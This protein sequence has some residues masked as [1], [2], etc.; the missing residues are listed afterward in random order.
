MKKVFETIGQDQKPEGSSADP[1]VEARVRLLRARVL[2][3]QPACSPRVNVAL[4]A[5]SACRWLK[6]KISGLASWIVKRR[7]KPQVTGKSD[8]ATYI[9]KSVIHFCAALLLFSFLC[10]ALHAQQ[11]AP[12]A[13]VAG[14][15]RLM[16]FS[17]KLTDGE[18]RLLPSVT[19]VTFSIYKDQEGGAPVWLETQNARPD[20]AGRYTVQLGA[21]KSEGLP[22]DLFSSGE[23]RWLGVQISGQPEQRRVLL[24]SVPYALKASDSETLGGLPAS[25]FMLAAPGASA[26]GSSSGATNVSAPAALPPTS[27]GG[28]GT[29]DYL[30]I[31][32][33]TNSV[34]N[35][36]LFQS[37]T[38]GS[39]KIGINTTTPA[40]TLDVKGSITFHGPLNFPAIN[41]ANATSGSNS[42]SETMVASSY[43]SG[44]SAGVN[45]KFRWQAEP[46]GNNTINA[47]GSLNLLFGS[48]SAT[49]D[50]TGLTI[51]SNGQ[52]TF[53]S[54]QAFPG[55]GTVASVG[56]SAPSSDFTV[57]GGPV[58]GKGTLALKWKVAPTAAATPNAIAKRNTSGGFSST[59]LET[60]FISAFPSAAS[61]YAVYGSETSG[62]SQGQ[63]VIGLSKA[64]IGVFGRGVYGLRGEGVTY[65]VFGMAQ[66]NGFGVVGD[67]NNGGGYGVVGEAGGGGS[68]G[69]YGIGYDIGDFGVVGQANGASSSV[70]V[71]GTGNNGATAMEGVTDGSGTALYV[72]SMAG[73]AINAYT[74]SG[75]TGILASVAS[76]YAGWFNGNVNIDGNLSKSGGSFKIDH[77]LDPANKYLYHSFVESPD[78]MN[79]YNGNVTTDGRGDA[80]VSL[81]DWFETLNRDFRYQLTVIGQFAQAIVSEE[82]AAGRFT[83]KTDKP[84]VKVSWQVTGIRQDAWAKAHP[85]PV[86]EVKPEAERGSYLHPELYGAPEEKGVLWAKFPQATKQW[87]ETHTR[88]ARNI[89]GP[90]H[91]P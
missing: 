20:I 79:I 52:I 91:K 61:T 55:A 19:G 30:P 35:S 10:T 4:S 26:A 22:L 75:G 24:L 53:A 89:N 90:P 9:V 73:P 64:G 12:S 37:G 51:A 87:K 49:P 82:I 33:G 13:T 6:E 47:S 85:I 69:V 56:L 74:S 17:G 21:S 25:A 42:Q 57:S 1:Q 16:S 32:T 2:E 11:T 83:I 3:Q 45:Q 58:T 70:G 34:G 80:V 46:V 14:V 63:G 18:G 41:T 29:L 48:G 8:P 7:T 23:A 62:D 60:G 43:N 88:T 65:G 36:I 44:T 38:G 68:V 67:A 77:P 81:P 50:E 27:L 31:W 28:S 59:Y 40:A 84:N 78:M 66:A 54:G 5:L 72:Q 86:E 39:A 71:R 15:P 76:G